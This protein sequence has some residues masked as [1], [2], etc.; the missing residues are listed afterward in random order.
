MSQTNSTN[1]A[2]VLACRPYPW[3][4]GDCKERSVKPAVVE[5]TCT[6]AYDG[7]KYT[8]TVPDLE[9]PRC[10]KCGYMVMISEASQ[11][12]DDALRRQLGLLSPE[13]IKASREKL[14]LSE[15]ELALRLGVRD[16]TV[17]AWESGG[18]IQERAMDNL[19]R[20]FFT[21]PAVAQF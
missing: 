4:C 14:G 15:A 8:V 11:R 17:K 12:I 21:M 19:L 3:K 1:P 9:I 16:E 13:E 5:Y 20:L 10:E 7:G 6:I 18:Q 2:P